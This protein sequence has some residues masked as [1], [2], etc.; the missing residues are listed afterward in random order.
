M[1]K[2]NELLKEEAEALNRAMEK[3]NEMAKE[4]LHNPALDGIFNMGLIAGWTEHDKWMRRKRRRH[5]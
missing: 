3:Y 2:K 4:H 5:G 1:K